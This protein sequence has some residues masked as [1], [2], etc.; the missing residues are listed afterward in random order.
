VEHG[1]LRGLFRLRLAAEIPQRAS[2]DHTQHPLVIARTAN[3]LRDDVQRALRLLH[4][5]Q[6]LAKTVS[7]DGHCR[8]SSVLVLTQRVRQ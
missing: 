5:Q 6:L 8:P 2:L 4:L 1:K 7:S 3:A